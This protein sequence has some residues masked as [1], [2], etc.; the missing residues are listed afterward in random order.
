MSAV[1]IEYLVQDYCGTKTIHGPTR[2]SLQRARLLTAHKIVLLKPPCFN[3]VRVRD[4]I[5]D[6][7]NR[8]ILASA[9]A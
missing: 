9:L 6:R 5:K 7:A 4:D 1:S 8:A 2:A 3:L